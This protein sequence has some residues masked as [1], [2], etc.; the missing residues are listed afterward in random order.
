MAP[1]LETALQVLFPE[2]FVFSKLHRKVSVIPD[3][4]ESAK[5]REAEM[6]E[7]AKLEAAV[8]RESELSREVRGL[9]G[10]LV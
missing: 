8:A 7:T 3:G 4:Q 1:Y 9:A 5:A 10:G 6:A 2:Q